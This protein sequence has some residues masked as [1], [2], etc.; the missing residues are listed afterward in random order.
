MVCSPSTCAV[1]A[2]F[3]LACSLCCATADDW[4]EGRATFYGNEPW[5]WSIHHGSECCL[6]YSTSTTVSLRQHLVD[7]R[8]SPD[9]CSWADGS[10]GLDQTRLCCQGMALL[11][12]PNAGA[13][14]C[15]RYHQHGM[16]HA[17]LPLCL[18]TNP[19][20]ELYAASGCKTKLQLSADQLLC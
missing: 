9:Q 20:R 19:G 16:T 7:S 8:A 2:A 12:T 18:L 10:P 11:G 4:R 14:L 1:L 3:L 6:G 17:E 13:W 15:A 5:L